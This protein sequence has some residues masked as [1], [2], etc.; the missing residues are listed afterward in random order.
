ML[1][2]LLRLSNV[3]ELEE[4]IHKND[5]SKIIAKSLNLS[6]IGINDFDLEEYTEFYNDLKFRSYCQK[7]Y[8]DNKIQE[9]R[10]SIDLS[11]FDCE[12]IEEDDL[13]DAPAILLN[14]VSEIR[15]IE[16]DQPAYLRKRKE[17]V[18]DEISDSD[19]PELKAFISILKN[20]Q[21]LNN[22]SIEE[23]NNLILKFKEALLHEK[24]IR[25]KFY[26]R[27]S[28][29]GART[30]LRNAV[31]RYVLNGKCTELNKI[32]DLKK[33][34][35]ND[36]YLVMDPEPDI[37]GNWTYKETEKLKNVFGKELKNNIVTDRSLCETIRRSLNETQ[38]NKQNIKY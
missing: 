23:K 20:S 10:G 13:N 35:I 37:D 8:Q 32:T 29:P 2:K 26:A 18:L 7:N 5:I 24:N 16:N 12:K 14:K 4:A 11:D 1:V 17:D 22:V 9:S 21:T 19:P 28:R 38:I 27:L 15:S 31:D 33:K 34:I 6:E 30:K 36:G 25:N 3:Y